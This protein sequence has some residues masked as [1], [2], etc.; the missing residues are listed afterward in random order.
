MADHTTTALRLSH[1]AVEDYSQCGEKYRLRRIAK[2]PQVPSWALVGGSAFHVVTEHLD[3]LDFG[4]D[5]GGPETFGEA[6]LEEIDLRIQESGVLPEYWTASGRAS[7]EWPDKENKD[8]W[9]SQGPIWLSTYRRFLAS[10]PWQ[11]WITPDGQPAVELE[12]DWFI[13]DVQVRGFIDRI[14]E[15][16]VTGAL[17]VIDIKTGSREPGPKQL[18]TYHNGLSA[19]WRAREWPGEPP[20]WGAF[21]MARKGF[22]SEPVDIATPDDG[23][24][25]HDYAKAALGIESQ[26]FLPSTSALCGSCSVRDYCREAGGDKAW[27]E[28]PYSH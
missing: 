5:D 7:K 4:Y 20:R 13:G 6:M 12:L 15:N 16:V 19:L 21:Y 26:I 22:M 17:A 14:Y 25:E 3:N 10:S 9:L 1:S 27:Q 2:V 8:F 24:L 11:V 23:R 28:L 18:I